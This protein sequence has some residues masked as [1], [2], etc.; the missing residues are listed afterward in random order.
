MN[1]YCFFIRKVNRRT[2][3][4]RFFW[5]LSAFHKNA[6]WERCTG[7]TSDELIT[8]LLGCLSLPL[9]PG[10]EEGLLSCLSKPAADCP[11]LLSSSAPPCSWPFPWAVHADCGIVYIQYTSEW[12]DVR[13]AE[14]ITSLTPLKWFQCQ[15]KDWSLALTRFSHWSVDKW[16]K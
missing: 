12:R 1:T 9:G 3:L 4:K 15:T 14:D 6:G 13:A 11:F 7:N 8:A 16:E 5:D 2:Y 10:A